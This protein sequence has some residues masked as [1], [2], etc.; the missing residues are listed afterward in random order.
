MVRLQQAESQALALLCS[1]QLKKYCGLNA[2][3]TTWADSERPGNTVQMGRSGKKLFERSEFFFP[4]PAVLDLR[5]QPFSR[6]HAGIVKGARRPLDAPGGKTGLSGSTISV[7]RF[8]L[9]LYARIQDYL[10]LQKPAMYTPWKYI[11]IESVTGKCLVCRL[12]LDSC[13][14]LV[15][16]WPVRENFSGVSPGSYT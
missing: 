2:G 14:L 3:T 8:G 4:A 13:H 10:K 12:K 7:K 16:L 1:N 15:V 5:K 9:T 6:R 11:I